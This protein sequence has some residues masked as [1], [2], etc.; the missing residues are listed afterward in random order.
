MGSLPFY[1]WKAFLTG[2][3]Q[4][5]YERAWGG[6]L[7]LLVLIIFLFVLARYFS[8]RRVK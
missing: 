4:E 5:S 2:G 8:G 3:T 7:V 1:I 6:M